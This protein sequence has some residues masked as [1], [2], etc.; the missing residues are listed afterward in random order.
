MLRKFGFAVRA[1]LLYG[2]GGFAWAMF[3]CAE[4][5]SV[6]PSGQTASLQDDGIYTGYAL[7]AG[8]E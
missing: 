2:T 8:A 3:N 7:G 5:D 4:L 6:R 1:A